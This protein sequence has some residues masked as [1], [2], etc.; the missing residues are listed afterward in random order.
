LEH[1]E[2]IKE[3]WSLPHRVIKDS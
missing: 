3:G 1:Q 2:K